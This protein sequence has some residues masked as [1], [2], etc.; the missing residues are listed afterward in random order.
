MIPGGLRAPWFAVDI[1]QARSVA[2]YRS[3]ALGSTRRGRRRAALHLGA[4][5]AVFSRPPWLEAEGVGPTLPEQEAAGRLSFTARRRRARMASA[6]ARGTRRGPG[7][8]EPRR[9]ELGV[10]GDEPAG[11][12]KRWPKAA[13]RS[14]TIWWQRAIRAKSCRTMESVGADPHMLRWRWP[15]AVDHRAEDLTEWAR[16]RPPRFVSRTT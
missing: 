15:R 7:L 16:I 10:I 3:R 5:F 13:A 9:C 12:R 8:P 2:L 11:P 1:A 4:G 6:S 14:P